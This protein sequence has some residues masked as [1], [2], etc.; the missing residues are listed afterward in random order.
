MVKESEMLRQR[1]KMT[2]YQTLAELVRDKQSSLT[3]ETWATVILRG[4]TPALRT[5]M[6]MMVELDYPKA[7]IANTLRA[8]GEHVIADLITP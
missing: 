7:D 5:L 2:K 6:I 1:F 3:V 4:N 8:R